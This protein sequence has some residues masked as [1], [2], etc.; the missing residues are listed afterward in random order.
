MEFGQC[1]LA[2]GVEW[3]IQKLSLYCYR[4]IQHSLIR[5]EIS[6]EKKISRRPWTIFRFPS[7][8]TVRQLCSKVQHMHLLQNDETKTT[9][10]GGHWT[11]R[12]A[13][14]TALH[15]WTWL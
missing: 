13:L 8:D 3:R 15:F 11:R 12:K 7:H 6:E 4:R 1:I 9:Y 5:A 2:E 14:Q 10:Q